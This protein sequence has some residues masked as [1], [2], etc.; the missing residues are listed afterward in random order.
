MERVQSFCLTFNSYLTDVSTH[1]IFFIRFQIHAENDFSHDIFL[2]RFPYS[3]NGV[4]AD[5]SEQ[6]D[7]FLP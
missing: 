6:I 2:L 1:C 3:G 4:S 7:S 5:D